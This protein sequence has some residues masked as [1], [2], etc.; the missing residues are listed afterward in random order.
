MSD[1][2]YLCDDAERPP[3]ATCCRCGAFVCREHSVRLVHH[4][5]RRP[6][7]LMNSG[8]RKQVYRLE[9]ICEACNLNELAAIELAP[10]QTV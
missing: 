8:G 1:R 7:G 3:V 4:L 9:I 2:C 6:I 10:G 5:R